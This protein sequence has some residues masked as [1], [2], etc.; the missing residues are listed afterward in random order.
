MPIALI[1]ATIFYFSLYHALSNL[2][3]RKVPSV[4]ATRGME[5][6]ITGN[7]GKEDLRC[8][9]KTVY[10]TTF[11]HNIWFY[12]L[13]PPVIAFFFIS[14]VAALSEFSGTK[15]ELRHVLYSI[16]RST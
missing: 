15:S 11:T 8:P 13:C 9:Q 12:L 4:D 6:K 2:A 7:H 5:I 14:Y 16:L 1:G 3:I 10:F